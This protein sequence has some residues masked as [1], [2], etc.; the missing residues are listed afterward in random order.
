MKKYINEIFFILAMIIAFFN[1]I[2][3]HINYVRYDNYYLI[4]Y[5]ILPTDT[6]VYNNDTTFIYR[7][8]RDLLTDEIKIKE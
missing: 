5:T 2:M 3:F 6:L 8:R 1:G 7:I 4:D